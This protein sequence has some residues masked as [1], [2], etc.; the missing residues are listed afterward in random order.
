MT[1][2]ASVDLNVGSSQ[3]HVIQVHLLPLS[4]WAA[5][6]HARVIKEKERLVRGIRSER[7]AIEKPIIKACADFAHDPGDQGETAPTGQRNN[8]GVQLGSGHLFFQ[9]VIQVAREIDAARDVVSRASN[10][11]FWQDQLSTA[12][13]CFTLDL[14]AWEKRPVEG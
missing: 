4:A 2:I 14:L 5:D 10:R 9:V 1:V 6:A 3:A 8:P 12:V 11:Q 7:N 13:A